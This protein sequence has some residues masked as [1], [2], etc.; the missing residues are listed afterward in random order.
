MGS[1]FAD[2]IRKNQNRYD[3]KLSGQDM[4]GCLAGYSL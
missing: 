1:E 2:S 4:V 3:I